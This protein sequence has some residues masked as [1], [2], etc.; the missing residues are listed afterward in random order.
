MTRKK[1]ENE[2]IIRSKSWWSQPE[3]DNLIRDISVSSLRFLK[4]KYK[5]DIKEMFSSGIDSNKFHDYK[6]M[7]QRFKMI[8]EELK[9]RYLNTVLADKSDIHFSD[10]YEYIIV[11]YP[12]G[13]K[14]LY[15]VS[16]DNAGVNVKY[17]GKVEDIE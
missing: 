5:H 9:K 3:F 10:N 4:Y 14:E 2:E 15:D 16:L 8:S 13:F 7:K 1:S 6:L 11:E 12:D 17:K